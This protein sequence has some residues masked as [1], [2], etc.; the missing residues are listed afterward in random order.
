MMTNIPTTIAANDIENYFELRA[1]F[2]T[3]YE[4]WL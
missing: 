1:M 3:L 4:G 2:L